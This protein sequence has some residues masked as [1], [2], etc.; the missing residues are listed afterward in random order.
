MDALSSLEDRIVYDGGA[1]ESAAD[2]AV[3]ADT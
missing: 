1:G 3:T 2:I